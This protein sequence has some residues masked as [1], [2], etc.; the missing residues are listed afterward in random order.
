MHIK[1]ENNSGI[2]IQHRSEL[3]LGTQPRYEAHSDLRFEI[4]ATQAVNI[5]CLGFKQFFS[6]SI[7]F[8][9]LS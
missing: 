8:L 4:K 3:E 7:I 9:I 1:M 6:N 2:G 5:V